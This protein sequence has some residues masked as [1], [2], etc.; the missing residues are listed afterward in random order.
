MAS[1]SASYSWSLIKWL[2]Q[3]N[4]TNLYIL[5]DGDEAGYKGAKN[6]HLQYTD[7][8]IINMPQGLDPNDLAN[9][10]NF[11]INNGVPK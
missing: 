10:E 4:A 8:I 2:K 11:L 9:L 3:I 5:Y 6:L 1:L 7:S